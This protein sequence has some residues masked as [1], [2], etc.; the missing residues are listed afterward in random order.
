MDFAHGF[1]IWRPLGYGQDGAPISFQALTAI[2][3]THRLL[4]VLTLLLLA[5][6]SGT[7]VACPV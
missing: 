3:Y 4:A 2:H 7:C 6:W 1:E 5:G